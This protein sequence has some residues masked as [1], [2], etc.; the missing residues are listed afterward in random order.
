MCVCMKERL[1]LLRR[2]PEF[3]QIDME[4]SFSGQKE[5]QHIVEN[6]LIVRPPPS[7]PLPLFLSV[8]LS[9]SI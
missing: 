3:S 7:L 1:T 2:Q 5:I 9:F 6:L 8:P 4:M